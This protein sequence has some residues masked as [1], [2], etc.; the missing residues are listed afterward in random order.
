MMRNR[1]NLLTALASVLVLFAV[2][3]LAF[4]AAR[5]GVARIDGRIARH[6]VIRQQ[7][8][9][10]SDADY[11]RFLSKHGLTDHAGAEDCA[12]YVTAPWSAAEQQAWRRRG[13]EI[14]PDVWIPPVPGRHAYGFH[15]ARVPYTLLPALARDP[16]V[17]R[18]ASTELARR[19][20]NDL[21]RA[22]IH[23]D[24][25]QAGVPVG[26]YDGTGV[27]ICIADS[28]LDLTHPDI[29][30]PVEAFDVTTGAT[31]SKWSKT[32]A[33]TVT[34][35]GTHVVGTA[36]GNGSASAGKY[37]G[38]APGASLRFYKIADNVAGE[39]VATD[40]IKAIARAAAVGC[41][42][43]SM[44]YGSL[45]D[46][47]DGSSA[48]S[49]AVD[50]ATATGMALFFVA[51]NDGVMGT[52]AAVPLAPGA[53]ASLS[54]TIDNSAG[55][56]A[57]KDGWYITA[58]WRDGDPNDHNVSLTCT[59]CQ[60]DAT[61][62]TPR[63]T[64]Q[65]AMWFTPSV[66][67]GAKK[68]YKLTLKNA[69]AGGATTAHVY[70]QDPDDL[71]SF[72]T[73]DPG[74][75]IN[76]PAVADTALSVGAWIQRTDWTDLAGDGFTNTPD[77]VLHTVAPFSSQGPRID[78][79]AR[80]AFVAPGSMTISVRDSQIKPDDPSEEID[81]HYLI[82]EGTSMATPCAAGAAAL[83]LQARPYLKPAALAKALADAAVPQ[84]GTPAA[85]Q[86]AGLLDI[87]ASIAKTP[88][89]GCGD[90]FCTGNQAC[91]AGVCVASGGPDA[92]SSCGADVT[93]SGPD[94][95]QDGAAAQP[96]V[97]AVD[98]VASPDVPKPAQPDA[99]AA[100]PDVPA[101]ADTGAPQPGP[102]AVAAA[103]ELPTFHLDIG[104]TTQPA[105]AQ[106]TS[107]PAAGSC[108]AGAGGAAA[109]VWL[110]FAAALVL[111]AAGRL[112]RRAPST[113]R[114][115]SEL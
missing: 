36:V 82:E 105:V 23:A 7:V 111:W 60:D 25:V 18:I 76:A 72:A 71:S 40:E 84:A 28:G 9:G 86:G 79:V 24:A 90:S 80:P 102:D 42:I 64:E 31:V 1:F 112:T 74:Y 57:I 92:C 104:A 39:S 8:P 59:N 32:V 13:V 81:A 91:V 20:R 5:P 114:G 63:G 98:D 88:A 46:D 107:R 87:Q 26:P 108:T 27:S 58:W 17:V 43:F 38:M 56:T 49:Q 83:V 68:T 35:H 11:R 37:K 30:K 67:A 109:D 94:A 6:A 45:G 75:T 21:A 47:V 4:A 110:L 89:T 100:P 51:G 50:A 97:A 78:G 62:P 41:Q 48:E 3:A 96:D 73:S 101:A 65:H 55:T 106:A 85:V 115:P 70:L 52:H 12:V 33:N 29:P 66:A 77:E 19:P 113:K 22:A 34:N 15:L 99:V 95:A 54:F 16:R 103:A 53:S 44:S 10:S 69:A 61:D 14:N 93:D 2:A